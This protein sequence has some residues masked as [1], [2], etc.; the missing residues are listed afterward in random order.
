VLFVAVLGTQS[1]GGR[2]SGHGLYLLRGKPVC[3]WNLLDQNRIRWDGPD[4]LTPGRIGSDTLTGVNN[5]DDKSPFKLTARSNKLMIKVD[6]PQLSEKGIQG[7]KKK[8]LEKDQV[9]SARGGRPH[10][11]LPAPVALKDYLRP[12]EGGCD[13]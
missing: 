10:V 13:V 3:R 12:Y 11:G 8:L 6:R 5:E 1:S 2:F 7:L 9:R 4:R